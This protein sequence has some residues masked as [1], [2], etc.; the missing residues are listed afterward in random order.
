LESIALQGRDK[1]IKN[2]CQII[3]QLYL[4]R[5]ANRVIVETV[6]FQQVLRTIFMSM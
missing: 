6:A 5:Q 2:A 1:N 3:K 4:K